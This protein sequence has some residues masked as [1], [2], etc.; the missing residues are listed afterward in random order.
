MG[1]WEIKLNTRELSWSHG[2]IALTANF[3]KLFCV[4][5]TNKAVLGGAEL[6]V[7]LALVHQ[8]VVDGETQETS[9]GDFKIKLLTLAN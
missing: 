4:R 5:D 6:L 2:K 7:R 9:F 1:R 3:I 8:D